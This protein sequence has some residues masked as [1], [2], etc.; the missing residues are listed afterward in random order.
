ME[1]QNPKY[2]DLCKSEF[3]R[4]RGE[5][6]SGKSKTPKYQ[7][8]PKFQFLG[9]GVGDGG[10]VQTNIPEILEWNTQGILNQNFWKLECVV[11]HR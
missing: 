8:L 10:A 4:G 7:D 3:L 2:Q 6:G 1:S 11:H 9:E 5:G